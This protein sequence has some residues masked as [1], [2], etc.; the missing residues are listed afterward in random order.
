MRDRIRE[1]QSSDE[2]LQ[3]WRPRDQ[4]KGRKLNYE[5]DGIVRYQDRL[6]VPS[7]DSLRKVIMKEV[8]NSTHSSWH[9]TSIC[10]NCIGGRAMKRVFANTQ[11]K[12]EHQTLAGKLKPVPIPELKLE[13]ITIDFVVGLPRTIRGFNA[14]WLPLVEVTYNNS[15]QSFIAMD[16][17]EEL[18]GRNCRSSIHWDEVFE[19]VEFGPDLIKQT[20]ELVVKIRDRMKTA[21]SRQK[22]YADKWRRELEF[23]VGDH[24]FV[25]V[26][27]MKGVMRIGKK[28][29]L[30]PRFIGL[31]EILEK[32][33]TL[34]YRVA[35]PPM[36]VGVHNVFHIL[37]LLKYMSNP[38]HVLNHEPL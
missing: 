37:M 27:P 6:W 29:K 8:H 15:Y 30:S 5:E 11:V 12:A 23:A 24:L 26:A 34:A 32:I 38:S 36:L 21:Q 19:R 28:G 25:K 31:F 10:K 4:S 16:S 22:S 3:K 13:N 9:E 17:Y 33:G 18:Y 7:G 14:I 2:E 35:L 1:V 20:T